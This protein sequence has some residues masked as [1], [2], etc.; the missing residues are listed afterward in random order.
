LSKDP[1]MAEACYQIGNV[2]EKDNQTDKAKANYEKALKIDP[3]HN[4]AK[5]KLKGLAGS[6]KS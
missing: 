6:P 2:W 3:N 1:K 4:W 5:K